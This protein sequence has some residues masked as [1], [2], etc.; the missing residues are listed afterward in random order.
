M[1]GAS[2]QREYERRTHRREQ[3]IRSRHRLLGGLILALSSEPV[4]TRV[5]AQGAAGERA[6]AATLEELTGSHVTVL[7]DRRLR[8]PDGRLSRANID[9]LA[10]AATG[11]W[12]IDAKTHTGALE[13]RRTGGLFT[14]R[15]ETLFI[16]G[17][18]QTRL[19]E[20]LTGQ[21]ESVAAELA[22]VGADVPVR[23][24]LCF[25]GTELP[26]FG[27]NIAGVPLVG[28]RGLAKLIKRPGELGPADR[29]ALAAHLA[30][31]FP[32]AS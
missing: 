2:A 30:T 18:D 21:V 28:R 3:D 14:P 31:R 20:G 11:V 9:H 6:V 12:V 29:D 17:R 8:R 26:W 25:V 27:E 32:A 15:T 22:R 1:A 24:A 5:W 13:V 10:V 7:H 16:N 4:S 23:G 19:I